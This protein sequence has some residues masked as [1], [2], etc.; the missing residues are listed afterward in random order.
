MLQRIMMQKGIE[1]SILEAANVC[2][3]G[4]IFTGLLPICKHSAKFPVF[5]P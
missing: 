5:W 4:T 3:A 2:F 1:D